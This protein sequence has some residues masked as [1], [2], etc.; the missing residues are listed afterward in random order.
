MLL[1]AT[2]NASIVTEGMVDSPGV[3]IGAPVMGNPMMGGPAQ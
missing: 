3:M 2:M 1:S